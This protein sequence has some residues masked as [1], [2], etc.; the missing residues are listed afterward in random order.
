MIEVDDELKDIQTANNNLKKELKL[1]K[2][3][4][5]LVRDIVWKDLCQPCH[6]V[7]VERLSTHTIMKGE[8][9]A[10]ELAPATTKK[11]KQKIGFSQIGKGSSIITLILG[12]PILLIALLDYKN[13]TQ[14]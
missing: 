4:A 14:Q 10:T 5:V 9:A 6:N 8:N 13:V 7:F 1:V 2:H 12:I 11:R 3:D